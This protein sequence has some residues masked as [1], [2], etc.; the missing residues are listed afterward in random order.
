VTEQSKTFFKRTALAVF[1]LGLVVAVFFAYRAQNN[2]ES[3]S[4]AET[5]RFIE[6]G[7][8]D[9]II[10]A[11]VMRT[12][13]EW[14]SGLSGRDELGADE[15]IWFDFGEKKMAGMWMK[16]M[17]FPIDI[18]WIDE[19]YEIITVAERVAPETYPKI[20]YPDRDAMFVL[21]LPAG[22]VEKYRARVGD[23]VFT[24]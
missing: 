17:K 21:E 18:V 6:I 8:N 12:P 11:E 23:S 7:L 14:Q 1:F 19:R 9:N 4:P 22:A 16:D 3:Q 5:P 20:F 13:Q 10:T 24:R 15:G 2:I